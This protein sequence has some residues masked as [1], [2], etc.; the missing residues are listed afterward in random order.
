MLTKEERM[1]LHRIREDY[2]EILHTSTELRD[3]EPSL[4]HSIVDQ[5]ELVTLRLD[6]DEHEKCMSTATKGVA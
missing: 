6:E 2:L 1:E 5:W 4:W 3:E